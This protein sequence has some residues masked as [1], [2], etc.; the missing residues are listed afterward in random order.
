VK[1]ITDLEKNNIEGMPPSGSNHSSS[2]DLW[3]SLN[4]RPRL[5]TNIPPG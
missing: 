2:F 5:I 1:E 4:T 3:A